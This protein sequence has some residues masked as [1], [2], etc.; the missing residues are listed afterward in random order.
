MFNCNPYTRE[1]T[2]EAREE[3]WEHI[4]QAI[5]ML[6]RAESIMTRDMKDFP[7]SNELQ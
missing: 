1:G 7:L 5:F 3:L 4:I 2:R 6:V